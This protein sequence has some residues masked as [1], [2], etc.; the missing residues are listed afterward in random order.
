MS[1]KLPSVIA[2]RLRIGIALGAVIGCFPVVQ[3]PAAEPAWWSEGSPP[4]IT[5]G[6]ARNDG[7]ANIGQAKWMVSE[8]LR[9]LDEVDASVS[10]LIRADLAAIVDLSVPDPKPSGWDDQQRAPLLLGQL[11]ALAYPF[12][13]HLNDGVPGWVMYQLQQNGLSTPGVNYFQD[14]SGRYL[15]WNPA[16]PVA[17]NKVVANIGQLKVVFSLRFQQDTDSDLIPDYWEFAS[18]LNPYSNDA[19]GD[20]DGDGLTNYQ[21]YLA[22]TDPQLTDTDGDGIPDS[23]EVSNGTDPLDPESS[24]IFSGSTAFVLTPFSN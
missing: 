21:E 9:V 8:A 7:V 22:G 3:S 2:S 20:A 10:S 18:G 1:K 11:K 5:G 4:V 24:D 6:A 17:K 16:T 23:V 15:P 19:A 14:G 13:R 12:Y